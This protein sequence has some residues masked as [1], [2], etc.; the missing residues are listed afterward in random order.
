M[1]VSGRHVSAAL[2]P[3]LLKAGRT[4]GPVLRVMEKRK[5]LAQTFLPKGTS[6]NNLRPCTIP[7]LFF[8]C[9]LFLLIFLTLRSGNGTDLSPSSWVVCVSIFPPM[10]HTHSPPPS[11]LLVSEGQAGEAWRFSNNV[12]TLLPP[13]DIESTCSLEGYEVWSARPSDMSNRKV[14][15]VVRSSGLYRQII[16]KT[17]C[18]TVCI[19]YNVN[20][21]LCIPGEAL[22]VPEG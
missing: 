12:M 17:G 19:K 8:C 1:D 9:F 10:L 16:V 20:Q 6:G 21:P 14:K 22:R 15:T 18:K 13:M 7:H 2:P 3:R 5:S 4:P 11:K